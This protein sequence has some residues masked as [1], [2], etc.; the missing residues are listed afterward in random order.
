MSWFSSEVN[1]VKIT[2]HVSA[3]ALVVLAAAAIIYMLGKFFVK[4]VQRTA[5]AAASRETRLNNIATQ[6]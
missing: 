6:R 5:T 4:H 3:I 2:D 1:T